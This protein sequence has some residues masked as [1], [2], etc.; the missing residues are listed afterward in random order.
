MKAMVLA[1]GKGER[2]RPVTLTLPKPAIP[3]LGRPILGQVLADLARRGV[4]RVA[5]NTHHLPEIVH[6]IVGDGSALGLEAVE[7]F[8]EREILLGT[9]GALRNAAVALRGEGTILV[10]N[11][12]FLADIDLARAAES[13]RASGLPATLVVVPARPGYT[14]V[15]VGRDGR[16][17]AIGGRPSVPVEEVALRATFT[18]CHLIEEEVLDRLP[19]TG[20]S[21]VVREVY[22]P[23]VDE[24][25]LGA[26]AHPGDWL[27]FGTPREYLDG[28]LA[29]L[30]LPLPRLRALAETDPIREIGGARIAVGPGAAIAEDHVRIRGRAAVGFASSLGAGVELEDSVVMPEAWLGS[31][32]RLTRC[33]VATGVEV[34]ADLRAEE[35]LLAQDADGRLVVRGFA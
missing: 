21:D 11:S 34:P 26:F 16:V 18:G 27:E 2:M 30:D 17:L 3:V 25:R 14:P 8:D 22:R 10:R 24:G 4:R 9:G 7:W 23:L 6:R 15:D 20:P 5:V 13:H 29:L 1:A 19:E 32:A 12:D 35:A 28:S 31:G 33:I